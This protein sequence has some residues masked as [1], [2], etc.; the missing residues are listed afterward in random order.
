[1]LKEGVDLI[2][3]STGIMVHR[4]ISIANKLKKYNINAGVIDV[5]RIKPLNQDLILE[6]VKN[7]NKIIVIEENIL[8]GG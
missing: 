1:M 3:I 6:L 8:T 2:I 4:A 7:Y 5:F